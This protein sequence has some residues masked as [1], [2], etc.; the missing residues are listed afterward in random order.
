MPN[1]TGGGFAGKVAFVT[2]AAEETAAA[3]L[4]LCSDGASSTTGHALVVDGDQTT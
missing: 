1:T 2:G 3:A 4:W